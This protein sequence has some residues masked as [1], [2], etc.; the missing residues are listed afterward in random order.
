MTLQPEP[1]ET[2]VIEKRELDERR[3]KLSV[4][5]TTPLFAR[6]PLEERA[7]LREQS[8]VMA[9]Y[10]DILSL[11][12]ETRDFLEAIKQDVF[13]DGRVS[14]RNQRAGETLLQQLQVALAVSTPME[15]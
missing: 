9:R 8:D 6:L 5:F 11:L 3:E 7:L 2:R 4:F 13:R 14:G 12:E 15:L 10:S 1:H